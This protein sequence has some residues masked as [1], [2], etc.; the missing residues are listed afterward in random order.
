MNHNQ[1]KNISTNGEVCQQAQIFYILIHT[2]KGFLQ[3]LFL[4]LFAQSLIQHT[5][6]HL[7][8]HIRFKWKQ[9]IVSVDRFTIVIVAK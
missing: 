8:A 6:E 9:E 1:M 3:T 4:L 2:L 7:K 5:Q